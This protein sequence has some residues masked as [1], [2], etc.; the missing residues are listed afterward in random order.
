LS[1]PTQSFP[2]GGG[3]R[4][5]EAVLA[6][7]LDASIERELSSGRAQPRLFP[8]LGA[9][10]APGFRQDDNSPARQNLLPAQQAVIQPPAIEELKII[11]L[12]PSPFG[13]AAV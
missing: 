11:K 10:S 4:S 6:Y 1:P 2:I 8:K 3:E 13:E 7:V 12:I 9:L 5:V